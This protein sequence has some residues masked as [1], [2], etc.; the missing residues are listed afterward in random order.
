[1]DNHRDFY[2]F[3]GINYKGDVGLLPDPPVIQP[4]EQVVVPPAQIPV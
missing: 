4:Q 1:M 3:I 2:R